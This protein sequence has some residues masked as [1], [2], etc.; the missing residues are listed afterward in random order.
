MNL[1]TKLKQAYL[2]WCEEMDTIARDKIAN[3][4]LENRNRWTYASLQGVGL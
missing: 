3:R 1:L 4:Y 2:K